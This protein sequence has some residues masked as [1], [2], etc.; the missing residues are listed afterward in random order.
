MALPRYRIP[1]T[2]QAGTYGQDPRTQNPT[3]HL[4]RHVLLLLRQTGQEPHI[5]HVGL[6]N[7]RHCPQSG[8]GDPDHKTTLDIPNRETFGFNNLLCL[9]DQKQP[10]KYVTLKHNCLLPANRTPF[11]PFVL[12]VLPWNYVILQYFLPPEPTEMSFLRQNQNIQL[13][14]LLPSPQSSWSQGEKPFCWSRLQ[15]L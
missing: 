3:R 13:L 11:S 2:L 7:Q 9:S 5:V 14:P 4:K 15:Y 6:S 10:K 8:S 1:S 12:Y